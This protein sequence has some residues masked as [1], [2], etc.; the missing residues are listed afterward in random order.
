MQAAESHAGRGIIG[1]RDATRQL[2]ALTALQ[3][4]QVHFPVSSVSAA[5]KQRVTDA[6]AQPTCPSY[7]CLLISVSGHLDCMCCLRIV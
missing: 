3:G 7:A 6:H 2:N 5:K 4:T 1:A